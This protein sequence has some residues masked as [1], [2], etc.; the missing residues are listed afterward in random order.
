MLALGLAEVLLQPLA[1]T[2]LIRR[3]LAR[4][5]VKETFEL[6]KREPKAMA[7]AMAN[8]N[9]KGKGKKKTKKRLPKLK[10][11]VSGE[12]AVAVLKGGALVV[13]TSGGVKGGS[14]GASHEWSWDG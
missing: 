5:P 11:G 10:L 2:N 6:K 12:I 13:S 1:I 3:A 7:M 14:R 9:R 4:L 8:T